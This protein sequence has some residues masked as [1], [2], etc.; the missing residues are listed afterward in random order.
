[1]NKLG[2]SI[3]EINLTKIKNNF[4]K[5]KSMTQ[6][7]TSV[8]CVVKANAYGLGMKQAATALYQ[9]GCRD[10][11]VAYLEEGTKL[12]EYVSESNIYV[13][14]GIQK[15]GLEE[16]HR[17]NLIPVLNDLYQIELWNSYA[18]KINKTLPAIIHVDTGMGRLGLTESNVYRVSDNQDFTSYL[19]IKY[20]MSHLA[21][22]DDPAHP[23]NMQQL[24]MLKQYSSLFPD[25]KLSFANSAGIMLGSQYHFDMVRPGCSLYGINPIPSLATPVEQVAK[26]MAEVV[27]IRNIE[28]DQGISYSSKHT[29]K[30]GDKVATLLCGYADG[31]LR[32]LTGKAFAYF[33]GMRLP[34]IG[35][36][37]MD[38]I[39]IDISKVP[40]SKLQ[41]M[42][43]VEL[44]GDNI[45]V[46]ELAKSA[47]T[48]GYEVLT[49][50]G[51]R[52]KRE[53]I[54]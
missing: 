14:N 32:S 18:S 2:R 40:E 1:M 50:L 9:A 3:L 39:M 10:F 29:A 23:A 42:N 53:Y 5:M 49:S 16:A 12:R 30:K 38:L 48:I 17:Q 15:D 52:F 41:S 45:T 31:Y 26:L 51:N 19:D 7:G 21:C 37:T 34:V 27:Q 24:N 13:F 20:I 6:N 47:G 4:L 46:D 36:V 54:E 8:S 33:D 25:I 43:Y 35:T 28:K 44:L 11:C 22:A